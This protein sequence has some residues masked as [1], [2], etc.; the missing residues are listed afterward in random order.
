MIEPS[1]GAGAERRLGRALQRRRRLHEGLAQFVCILVAV[2]LA[3][4]IPRIP[5]GFTVPGDETKTALLSIGAAIVP[6]IGIVFSLLF[7][8]V[9]FGSTTFTPRLNLF[10][11]APIVWPAFSY[12][13]AVFVFSFVAGQPQAFCTWFA[14]EAT[15]V[16]V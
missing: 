6:F 5:V 8:V 15:S 16:D 3:L 4:L 14:N 10:R 12:F 2:A 13:S 11:H 7:L 1:T 9:Q